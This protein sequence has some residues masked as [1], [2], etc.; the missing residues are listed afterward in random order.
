MPDTIRFSIRAFGAC[1][2]ALALAACTTELPVSPLAPGLDAAKSRNDGSYSLLVTVSGRGAVS[3]EDVQGA[4]DNDCSATYPSGTTVTLTAAPA[5]GSVLLGWSGAC[6]GAESTCTLTL[7]ENTMV[8]AAFGPEGTSS[9]VSVPSAYRL[10]R[11]RDWSVDIDVAAHRG[12][13]A[14]IP[15]AVV[16]V[17]LSGGLKGTRT[18]ITSDTGAC[19]IASGAISNRASEITFTITD[20]SVAGLVYAASLNHGLNPGNLAKA[21]SGNTALTFTK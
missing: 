15:G 7:R 8:G 12:D 19:R 3:T 1:F 2:T 6:S 9:H 18:C 10:W 13:P 21:V 14:T 5:N 17:E 20:V 4:C 16:T 11:T